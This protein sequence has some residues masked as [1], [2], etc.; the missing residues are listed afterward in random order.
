MLRAEGRKIK[1]PL[2]DRADR[3]AG[4]GGPDERAGQEGGK[5]R[6]PRRVRGPGRPLEQ[7]IEERYFW[8]SFRIDAASA[9]ISTMSFFNS[10]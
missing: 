8:C 2:G 7:G 6:T 4:I 5:K 3:L 9:R 10:A 1:K